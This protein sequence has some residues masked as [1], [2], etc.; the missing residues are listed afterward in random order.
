MKQEFRFNRRGQE[1]KTLVAAMSELLNQP[2]KYLGAPSFA[3][4]VGIGYHI[5]KEGTVT[6]EHNLN[7][8]VGLAER[9]FEPEPSKTFHLITPRGTL[10][11]QERFDT[12]AE[13]E[14]AGYGIYFHH[15]GR[16]VY[17]KAAPDGKTE[18]SKWFAV[19][20]APFEEKAPES[21]FPDRL[22]IEVPVLGFTP[23]HIENLNRMVLA[24][25][26]LIKKALGVD[27]IPIQMIVDKLL[28]PWFPSEPTENA[29]CYVQF[30]YALC[31]TAKEKKRV[32][33]KPKKTGIND[34]FRFRV[35]M[36]QLGM[37]GTEYK[38]AR[39][40]LLSKLEGN[41]SWLAGDPRKATKEANSAPEIP[42]PEAP[43]EIHAEDTAPAQAE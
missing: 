23:E 10:L 16:D 35:F 20:G 9:G 28:F 42:E 29:E 2:T 31:E 21:E 4:E 18:H 12:A 6:G 11:C 25:E 7:L 13:A 5:D 40:L 22:V 32:T 43:E 26:E 36:I 24:K 14:A 19:V 1:R 33:A 39:K 17:V 30:I 41:S 8:F 15:E 3:Y 27:E 37:V 38:A 34:K